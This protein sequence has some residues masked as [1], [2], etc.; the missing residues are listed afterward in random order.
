[1]IELPDILTTMW[2]LSSIG[3]IVSFIITLIIIETNPWHGRFTADTN[4]GPQ[5]IHHNVTSRIGGVA[6]FASMMILGFLGLFN[7][8]PF[9]LILMCASIPVFL[10]GLIEDL[11]GRVSPKVRFSLAIISGACFVYASGFTITSVSFAPMDTLLAMPII[12]IG[13][14]IFTITLFANAVNIIDG[15]N[16]LS[17]GTCILI[18]GA[19]AVVAGGVGD[20][21]L[22]TI[23]MLFVA[24]ISGLGLFNFPKGKIFVGDG[25]A[26]FMGAFIA[27]MLIMLPERNETVSPFVSLLLVIYPSYEMVR[28][29][30]RRLIAKDTKALQPD[31]KHLHSLVYQYYVRRDKIGLLNLNAYAGLTMLIFPLFTSLWVFVSTSSAEYGLVGILI[32]IA[33]YELSL[34]WI[35]RASSKRSF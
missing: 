33:G 8:S 29:T 15:L 22:M 1:M 25:G 4:D 14:T 26:Y 34:Y 21:Q 5:K 32:F 6:I 10:G 9:F 27:F 13:F 31:Q 3:F 20:I 2:F 18:A 12:A 16:G 17:V 35:L 30:I 23:S 28:S 7:S 19:I 24:V 11:T